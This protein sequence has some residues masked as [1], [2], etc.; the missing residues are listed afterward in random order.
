M[1]T[2]SMLLRSILGLLLFE[3]PSYH[4]MAFSFRQPT[5]HAPRSVQNYNIYG[6]SF[7]HRPVASPT[8]SSAL[9]ESRA[10]RG[11]G[12]G[13]GRG[14]DRGRGRGR[15]GE[16]KRTFNSFGH[17]YTQVGGPI[18]SSIC[19]LKEDDIHDLISER[20]NC[21][22]KRNF[23][24]ADEIWGELR[25]NGVRIN[26]KLGE[27]KFDGSMQARSKG[28]DMRKCE[29][30]EEAASM[31]HG[32]LDTMTPRD[33]AAFWTITSRLII[34]SSSSHNG[35]TCDNS[36]LSDQLN[37]LFS[38][39][40]DRFGTYY[41]QRELAQIAIAFAKISNHVRSVG[42]DEKGHESILHGIFANQ[43]KSIFQSIA[44]AAYPHLAK[45]DGGSLSN[46][47]YACALVQVS[48]T[49]DNGTTLLDRIAAKSI[50]LL[51]AGTSFNSQNLSNMVWAYATLGAHSW[52]TSQL[53]EKVADRIISEDLATLHPQALSTITWSY[54]KTGV[55]HPLLFEKVAD[56]IVISDDFDKKFYP[57]ALSS[58]LWS[59]AKAAVPH[60]QLFEK[61]AE[62]MI[63]SNNLHKLKPR[64]LSIMLWAMAKSNCG[65]SY[66][67][68]RVADEIVVADH[69]SRFKPKDLSNIVW[70]FATAD[71]VFLN[72]H[73]FDNV[74]QHIVAMEDLGSFNSQTI[75][76]IVWSYAK[77]GGAA[78]PRLFE[79]M[80]DAAIE[81]Q[82][83]FNSQ[84]ISSLLWAKA[85]SGQIDPE[86]FSSMSGVTESIITSCNEQFLA[87]IGWAYAVSNVDAGPLF[88]DRF[89]SRCLEKIGGFNDAQLSQLYQWH[90]WREELK[91]NSGLPTEF[92]DDCYNAFSSQDIIQ[93]TTQK[94]VIA[95]LSSIGLNPKEEFLTP[96]G[97]RLDALL[98]VNGKSI[99]VEVD[100]PSHFL[101][102]SPNGSTILKHRQV[103]HLE[104]ILIV[105][106]PFWEWN[107]HGEDIGK[108]QQYLRSLLGLDGSCC[109]T[110]IDD[111]SKATAS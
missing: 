76:N 74:A 98:E 106:V 62:E 7:R 102:R 29:T 33:M 48:P 25:E 90:L 83:D 79:I 13:G 32:S 69:L 100:G 31:A 58:I 21:K 49:F 41:H 81:K 40:M 15:G 51:C 10:G 72:P 16:K 103:S 8:I 70:A 95:E 36:L 6:H 75:S 34:N 24:R 88:H 39:A 93:S 23:E 18:D 5:I 45:A 84:E 17:D 14:R 61:V 42:N 99:G 19:K 1:M 80:A 111:L 63:A 66:F 82:D 60:R 104:G 71:E 86:F 37:A 30:V 28:P 53:F 96:K 26:D 64:E 92:V 108:K 52:L 54:A 101:G 4:V 56:A 94:E 50:P 91:S 67:Y 65:P 73:L 85:S 89:I 68:Q 35:R 27:W 9:L 11:D 105:S 78:Y 38:H 109:E 47:A 77:A 57:Q 46:L 22:V 44:N 55:S 20:M 2:L 87:N 97:Y 110:R 3:P 43:Q 107:E 12:R 59:Y